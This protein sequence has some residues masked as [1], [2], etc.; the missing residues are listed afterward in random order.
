MSMDMAAGVEMHGLLKL[1]AWDS[2]AYQLVSSHTP[3]AT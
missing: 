3:N 2:S 1:E